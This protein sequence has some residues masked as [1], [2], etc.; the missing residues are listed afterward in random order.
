MKLGE[1]IKKAVS[2]NDAKLAGQISDFARSRGMTYNI[3]RDLFI[4]LTDIDADGFEALMY[5]ADRLESTT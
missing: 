1:V 5:E 2:E 4:K 3:V